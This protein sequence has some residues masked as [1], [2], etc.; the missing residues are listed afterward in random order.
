MLRR[1]AAADAQSYWMSAKMPSDAFLLY[2]FAGV[3]DDLEQAIGVIRGR[4]ED[5]CGIPRPHS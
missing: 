1:L 4:A 2:G 5:V 3:P